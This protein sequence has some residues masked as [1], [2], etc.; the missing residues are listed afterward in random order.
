[1]DLDF[2]AGNGGVWCD[3]F[4]PCRSMH[5]AAGA[6][7]L[8]DFICVQPWSCWVASAVWSGGAS[9][10]CNQLHDPSLA[11]TKLGCMYGLG[12]VL[13]LGYHYWKSM[14]HTSRSSRHAAAVAAAAQ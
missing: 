9:E 3:G 4:Y 14:E 5:R 6:L 12:F 2:T 8:F 7:I 11:G 10:A 13:L 1:M